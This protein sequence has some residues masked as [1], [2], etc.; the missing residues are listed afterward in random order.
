M[1]T[2]ENEKARYEEFKKAYDALMLHY[3]FTLENLPGEIWADIPDYDGDYQESNFGRTK[4][5]KNGRGKILK[6]SLHENGYLR[7]GLLKES[8]A[9][10]YSVHC[11]VAQLFVPNPEN[12]PIVNH[13]DGGRF[14]NYF[15]NLE[16]VTVKENLEHAVKMGL[17]KSGEDNYQAKLTADQVREIRRLY[18]KGSSEFGYDG[19]AER[20]GVARITIQRVVNYERYKNVE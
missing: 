7:V 17:I 2:Y 6:P 19:L 18:V 1:N 15:E 20:Y 9:T 8:D 11:L 14:N 13:I 5:L 12:N 16:W 10:N 3:P 4:S